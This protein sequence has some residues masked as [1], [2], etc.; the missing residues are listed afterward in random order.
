M[1]GSEPCAV[2]SFFSGAMGLDL[3]LERAGL[4]VRCACEH[5]RHAQAT[6]R[7]N[8]PALPLLGDVAALSAAD[9]LAAAGLRR[10]DVLVVAGGPPC[11]AFSTA[12]KRRSFAEARGN[13]F[14]KF[15]EI[16]LDVRPPFIL[17]ENVRGLLS[18]ALCPDADGDAG[19]PKTALLHVLDT[20]RAGGYAVSFNL[21]NTAN[22]GVAQ[23]RERVVI[24]AA[25]SGTRCPYLPPTHSESAALRSAHNLLAWRTFRDATEG[26]PAPLHHVAFAAKH[27]PF[28]RMLGPGQNW[29]DLPEEHRATAMGKA[30]NTSGGRTGFLRRLAWD[31][32]SPTLVTSPAMPATAL[33]HPVADRPL[34][35]EEY[36]RLQG[37]PDD[38]TVS[39]ALADQYRQLGNA[40]P[41]PFGEAIGRLLLDVRDGRSVAVIPDFPY[42]RYRD[43]ADEAWE[44]AA[45]QKG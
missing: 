15:L 21:Y 33:A 30:Y 11:Q 29:R 37:F 25:R 31:R 19:R 39:G 38:W 23:C 20:L 28:Y 43:T 44:Q 17:I 34:A 9:V 32:P 7:A 3:G 26:M 40:V 5:D 41:V 35:V 6:I 22:Y 2:L 14:L 24:I 27:V 36:R 42:S 10:E 13:I 18:A 4:E 16:A 1:S 8:R 12:G 45:R